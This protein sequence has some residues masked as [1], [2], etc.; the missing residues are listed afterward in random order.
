MARIEILGPDKSLPVPDTVEPLPHP[1][2]EA[3]E[4]HILGVENTPKVA[5]EP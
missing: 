5:C 1:V 4:I 3:A 2:A